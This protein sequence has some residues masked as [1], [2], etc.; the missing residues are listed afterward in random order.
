M[1]LRRWCSLNPEPCKILCRSEPARDSGGSVSF[2][3]ADTP[4]S[5]AGSLLQ[6]IG[7]M[8][9]LD[10]I[11]KPRLIAQAGLF[12]GFRNQTSGLGSC[13]FSWASW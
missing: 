7:V 13:S 9:E 12:I 5:R 10:E 3:V 1:C 2:V 6:G 11:K 8:L 4:L